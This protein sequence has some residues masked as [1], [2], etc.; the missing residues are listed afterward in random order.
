MTGCTCGGVAP[1]CEHCWQLR[2]AVVN[3]RLTLV[4]LWAHA[5]DTDT[6][7]PD[8]EDEYRT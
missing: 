4:K 7:W 3:E 5:V 1:L 6:D 8:P 2:L